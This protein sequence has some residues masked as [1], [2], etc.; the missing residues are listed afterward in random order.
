MQLLWE[1]QFPIPN[2]NT[3]RSANMMKKKQATSASAVAPAQQGKTVNNPPADNPAASD[4]QRISP[5]AGPPT[6]TA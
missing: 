4:A 1:C 5:V 3:Q 2:P 6:T